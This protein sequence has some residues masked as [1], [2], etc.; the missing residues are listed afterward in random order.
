M[1]S[2]FRLQPVENVGI[3][4]YRR[5]FLGRPVFG[6]QHRFEL[7][8]RHGVRPS[9]ERQRPRVG[10]GFRILVERSDASFIFLA[11]LRRYLQ[12]RSLS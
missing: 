8:A 11:K 7:R 6:R 4:P 3:E 9:F 12:I 2:A 5:L 10:I 1:A